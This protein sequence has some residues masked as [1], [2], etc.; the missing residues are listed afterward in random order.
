MDSQQLYYDKKPIKNVNES[1]PFFPEKEFCSPYRSTVPLLSLIKDGNKLLSKILSDI[2]LNFIR[3]YHLEFKINPPRGGG[4][5]SQ[6]DLMIRGPGESLAIEA[7]WTEPRYDTVA[8]W[9][10]KGERPKNKGI[11]L[12]GWL[13]LIQPHTQRILDVDHFSDAVYQTVHRA[14]SACFNSEQPH[15]TYLHFIPDPSGKGA[16]SK[17]YQSDLEHLRLLLGYPSTFQF[18]LVNLEIRPTKI[19]E[20]IKDLPK[21]T[22]DTAIAVRNAF[23]HG[24]LFDFIDLHLQA[25]K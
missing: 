25:I 18:Y 21:D 10:K 2:G 12:R 19:F 17:Q 4:R 5:A 24:P 7:K 15:L 14:A 23:E 20:R 1:L 16:T 8:E 6:T 11:V 13:D 22:V 3:D 9:R